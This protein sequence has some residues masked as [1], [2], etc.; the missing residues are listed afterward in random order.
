MRVGMLSASTTV[1]GLP[2]SFY[3][4]EIVCHAASYFN[5]IMYLLDND[6][7]KTHLGPEQRTTVTTPVSRYVVNYT[8]MTSLQRFDAITAKRYL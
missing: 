2:D 4:V 1:I 6:C 8:A 7:S 3:K 5:K